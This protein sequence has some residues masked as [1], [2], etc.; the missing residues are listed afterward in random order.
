[1]IVVA[2]GDFARAIA[3]NGGDQDREWVH[4]ALR[5]IKKSPVNRL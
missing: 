2:A 3:M 1:M 5:R 4:N